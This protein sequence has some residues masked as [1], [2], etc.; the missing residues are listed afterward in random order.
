M[1]RLLSMPA[2]DHAEADQ[3]E[4]QHRQGCRFGDGKVRAAFGRGIPDR[5]VVRLV[6]ALCRVFHEADAVEGAVGV[7]EV[8]EG[9]LLSGI[10]IRELRIWVAAVW[11]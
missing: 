10:G 11:V 3:G 7:K 5:M 8:H 9:V 2:A 6:A 4:S 1:P